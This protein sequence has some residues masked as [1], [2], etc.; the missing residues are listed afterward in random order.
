MQQQ[1]A[2]KLAMFINH[3]KINVDSAITFQI[4]L[5][6]VGVSHI[7]IEQNRNALYTNRTD[8]NK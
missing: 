1:K 5:K 6:T 2:K 8:I 4:S 7:S 3:A